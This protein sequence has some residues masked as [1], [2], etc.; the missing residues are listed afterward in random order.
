MIVDL[1]RWLNAFRQIRR[2]R[3]PLAI[4]FSSTL[5]TF[6]FGFCSAM[7]HKMPPPPDD[8][9]SMW[10]RWDAFHFLSIAQH[11]YAYAVQDHHHL[12]AVLPVYPAV[13]WLVHAL[14]RDWHV[15]ALLVSNLSCAGAFI[16]LYLLARHEQNVASARRAVLFFAIFP[17]AYFLHVAYSESL[18][19]FLMFACFYHARR[20]QWL[21]AALL[22]MFAAATR[23]PGVAIL[24]AL[25][26]EY[27]HQ[28][29]FRWRAIRSDAAWLAL[30]PLGTLFYLWINYRY[31][32][33]PLFFLRTQREVWM[34]FM[35]S[36]VERI[37]TNWNLSWHSN[38][39]DRLVTYGAPFATFIIGTVA[40]VESCFILRPTYVVYAALNWLMIF[41]N[42]STVS[43][44]RYLLGMFP[45]FL[46]LAHF[47]RRAWLRDSLAIV[48]LMFY[49]LFVTQFTRG[50]WAF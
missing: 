18:F 47:T 48:S 9:F 25:L 15:A 3:Y 49:A 1:S 13:I 32:G 16:Y 40:V 30:I 42:N 24:P 4:A 45:L 29:N 23:L 17:T 27:L 37:L 41:C 14:A 12:I 21:V 2:V 5:A 6:I 20:Q 8:F 43:S 34:A 11:G 26:V 36:P 31:F 44:P 35:Q 46:V 22:G 28:R 33:D 39:S 19:F 38:M 10:R 7:L 50:W